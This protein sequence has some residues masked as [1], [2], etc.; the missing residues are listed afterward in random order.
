MGQ[1][2]PGCQGPSPHR[3]SSPWTPRSPLPMSAVAARHP[4]EPRLW[5]STSLSTSWDM[6]GVPIVLEV[7]KDRLCFR[8]LCVFLWT[9]KGQG[10]THLVV[11][12]GLDTLKNGK[13]VHST[14]LPWGDK[15]KDRGRVRRQSLHPSP[16]P[17]P[18]PCLPSLPSP[19][20]PCPPLPSSALERQS[21][22]MHP[23]R[24]RECAAPSSWRERYLAQQGSQGTPLPLTPPLPTDH[25]SLCPGPLQTSQIQP[26]WL[27]AEL[28][29]NQGSQIGWVQPRGTR[30]TQ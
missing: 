20:F 9:W 22:V 2:A 3:G 12:G 18:P 15:E 6:A 24:R 30:A 7:P 23:G 19:S 4:Q 17:A 1:D 26:G 8:L 14:W 5:V 29:L 13:G 28:T 11:Q 21:L 16:L 10:G 25:P 27:A